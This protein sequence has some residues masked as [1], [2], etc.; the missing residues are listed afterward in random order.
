MILNARGLNIVSDGAALGGGP[1]SGVGIAVNRSDAALGVRNDGGPAAIFPAGF[2]GIGTSTP[3][4]SLDVPLS[5]RFAG[6]GA[7]SIWLSTGDQTSGMWLRNDGT[8]SVIS[9]NG[10]DMYFGYIGASKN[11]RFMG[12]GTTTQLILTPAGQVG[13]GITGPGYPLDVNGT[14]H[15]AGAFIA[16]SRTVADGN[17]CYYA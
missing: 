11:L 1:S 8:S 15:A 5:V 14:I 17:G 13:I 3:A 16:G 10:A 4:A 9:S 2:V 12:G 7:A 6:T